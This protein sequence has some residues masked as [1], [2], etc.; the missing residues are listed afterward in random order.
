MGTGEEGSSFL[1][2]SCAAAEQCPPC[3]VPG[4][5]L[6]SSSLFPA[7]PHLHFSPAN[8]G[9][10]GWSISGSSATGAPGRAYFTLCQG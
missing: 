8:W 2:P 10:N 6:S 5:V 1:P 7:P 3:A 4:R 9:H